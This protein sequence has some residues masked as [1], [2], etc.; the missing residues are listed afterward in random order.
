MR[1]HGD[2]HIHLFVHQGHGGAAHGA[3]GDV[4][5]QPGQ[6]LGVAGEGD[7]APRRLQPGGVRHDGQVLHCQQLA[8][9]DDGQRLFFQ[10][11]GVEEAPVEAGAHHDLAIGQELRALGAGLPP[12][13]LAFHGVQ[14]AKGS[15]QARRG[16]QDLID[17]PRWH[18]VRHQG[19]LQVALGRAAQAPAPRKSLQIEQVR[20][21]SRLAPREKGFVVGEDRAVG[22]DLDA[23]VDKVFRAKILRGGRAVRRRGQGAVV[24]LFQ[25]ALVAT[26]QGRPRVHVNHIPQHSASL[27]LG[28]DL[29]Q[30][31]V[32]LL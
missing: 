1:P 23:A 25:Q 12:H 27:H 7:K 8:V 13:H 5:G 20:H 31:A 4:I 6:G 22:Q 11:P 28:A 21:F 10:G 9:P 3:V 18:A 15:G 26:R 30:L 2:A 19:E 17:L 29:R 24:H 32:E 16:G 14:F